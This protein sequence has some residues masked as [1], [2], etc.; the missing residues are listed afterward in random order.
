LKTKGL[1]K[2]TKGLSSLLKRA[3]SR[4]NIH[5]IKSVWSSH[6][7]Y[8]PT[9]FFFKADLEYIWK[10]IRITYKFSEIWDLSALTLFNT[11]GKKISSFLGV[12]NQMGSDKY[13]GLPSIIGRSKKAIFGYLKAKLWRRLNHWSHKQLSKAGKEIFLKSCAQAI[14]IYCMSVFLLSVS[15]EVQLQNMMNS[16]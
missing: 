3:K 10:S 2:I 5:G 15:L 6:T 16:F 11:T 7:F 4:G 9:T 8:L 13:L 12:I 14:P 1:W